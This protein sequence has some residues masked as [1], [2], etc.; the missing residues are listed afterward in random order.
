LEANGTEDIDRRTLTLVPTREGHSLWRDADGHAWRTFRCID[1]TTTRNTASSPDQAYHAARAFGVFQALLADLPPPRLHETI[2]DFHHTRKRFNDLVAA[3]ESDPHNRAA[4]VRPEIDFALA[5]EPI[6]D[7][8]HGL[9]LPERITHN[10]TKIANV[11]FDIDSGEGICVIDLDTTMPGL[12]A[13]DF[14]D[15][16]RTAACPAPEDETDLSLMRLHLPLFEALVRGYLDAAGSILTPAEMDQ[17]AFSGRLIA[18][19]I[20][21]RFLADYLR[22]D[23]YF[24]TRRPRHNLDRTRAQFA[25]AASIEAQQEAMEACVKA[26]AGND[27]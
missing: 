12:A 27:E 26:A 24:K 8:L 1:N 9:G 4:A 20:G 17:M 23:T 7:V 10:D 5:R 6:V 25:L 11:L 3:V 22:G 19:E 16:V 2:P 18:Y 14:G 15:L 13:H 21:I